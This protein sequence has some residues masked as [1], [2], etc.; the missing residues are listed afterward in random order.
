MGGID[1]L[2]LCDTEVCVASSGILSDVYLIF[3]R[4][5]RAIGMMLYG[6]QSIYFFCLVYI[7]I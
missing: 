4:L 6:K 5:F 7:Y 3:G 2:M 1:N